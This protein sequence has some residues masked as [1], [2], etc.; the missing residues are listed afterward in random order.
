MLV[1]FKKRLGNKV[2]G[3]DYSLP[4]TLS[5]MLVKKGYAEYVEAEAEIEKP[6]EVKK[7]RKKKDV[8]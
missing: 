3:K 2:V 8:N 1:K 7:A 4:Q 5:D 6:V